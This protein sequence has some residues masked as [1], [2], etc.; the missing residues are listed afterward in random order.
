MTEGENMLERLSKVVWDARMKRGVE[1][2]FDGA[3]IAWEDENETLHENVRVEVRALLAAI[4][5]EPAALPKSV[6]IG[7]RDYTIE[8]W[9]SNMAAGAHRYGECDKMN[10]II[11]VDTQFGP[12]KAAN[13]LLHE[14]MHACCDIGEREDADNEE[15]TVSVLAGTLTQVWRDNPDLVAFMSQA[16][17]TA[18]IPN[19]E[20]EGK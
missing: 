13:T 11:R 2:G 17:R 12:V 1:I 4:A 19:E 10:G 18:S 15:R 20:G 7:Y 8:N 9:A 14:I 5:G 6:R 3:V 16:L